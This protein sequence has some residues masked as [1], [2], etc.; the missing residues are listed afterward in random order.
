MRECYPLDFAHTDGGTRHSGEACLECGRKSA[1]LGSDAAR[2]QSTCHGIRAGKYR[3]RSAHFFKSRTGRLCWDWQSAA[4]RLRLFCLDR[5]SATHCDA[6]VVVMTYAPRHNVAPNAEQFQRA[7]LRG[8]ES[9]DSGKTVNKDSRPLR[10]SVPLE[11]P[12]QNSRPLSIW[13][14]PLAVPW[15]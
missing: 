8:R 15:G 10:V 12:K 7:F 2:D 14:L 5:R 6:L 1:H 3:L 11:F 13:S 4:C 9:I